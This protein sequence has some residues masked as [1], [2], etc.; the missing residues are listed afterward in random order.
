MAGASD[1]VAGIPSTTNKSSVRSTLP[2]L[3]VSFALHA[4]MLLA[5]SFVV[6]KAPL[7]QLQMIVDSVLSDER[8]Q[9]DFNHD[10]EQSTEVAATVNYV[11]GA[12]ASSGLS[13]GG[14]GGTGGPVVEQRKLDEAASIQGPTVKVNIG[15][16]NLPGLKT[17]S[18]DLG[19]GQVT[20]DIG[21]VVEGY[22]AA[23]GQMTMELLRLMREQ[24]VLAVWLF[25]ESDSMKDDQKEN[26][27][28]LF[29]KVYEELGLVQK[30]EGRHKPSDDV[31]LTTVMSFGK[32]THEHTPK[33]TSNT[34]EIKAAI[35]KIQVD[36]TG[37]EN[38]CG[39]RFNRSSE[40][41]AR[42]P[43][44]SIANSSS[45]WSRMNQGTTEQ[46]WK[47]PSTCASEP[48]RPSIFW[49][50]IRSS[51]ILTRTFAG[52]T[53]NT[54]CR[55]GCKSIAARKL[56]SQ[57]ACNSTAFTPAGTFFRADSGRM[58]R[59]ESPNKPVES[60]SCCR[61]TKTT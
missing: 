54:I 2:G 7:E 55:I 37:V 58:N 23:L 30:T 3:L 5:L 13:A 52:S 38:F 20:G 4:G 24:R 6:F 42:S 61:E 49:A 17:I 28:A 45:S 26:S 8:A 53:R 44:T 48:R 29:F 1:N 32:E 18:H 16:M 34:E 25:D 39:K 9:E 59:F 12:M 33:P 41:M 56:P 14:G 35:D 36:E 51:D 50:T 40:N 43:K 22:G 57:N 21:R 19:A 10:V 27:R 46:T 60:S 31:L 15:S 47:K 11:A